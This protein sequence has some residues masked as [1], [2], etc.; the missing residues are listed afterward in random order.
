MCCLKGTD[1][2]RTLNSAAAV[3]AGLFP[4]TDEEIWNK[5]LLWH[6][7]PI[8]TT[9]LNLEKLL[10]PGKPC[11]RLDHAIKNYLSSPEI[12]EL[13]A[14]HKQ[15]FQ[16]LEEHTGMAIR[17]STSVERLYDTLSIEELKNKT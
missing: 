11:P 4:P 17:N 16:Y 13:Y 3:L 9:P 15:L 8:H 6:P 5:A 12:I 14:K 2:D 1:F 10:F 7:I